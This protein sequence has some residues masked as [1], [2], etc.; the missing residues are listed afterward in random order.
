[1]YL[2]IS[3]ISQEYFLCQSIKYP[4]IW[5]QIFHYHYLPSLMRTQSKLVSNHFLVLLFLKI[6]FFKYSQ[7]HIF[8]SFK[9]LLIQKNKSTR[10]NAFLCSLLSLSIRDEEYLEQREKL[11]ADLVGLERPAHVTEVFE[12]AKA[13]ISALNQAKSRF[14]DGDDAQ[15]R[16][17]FQSLCSNPRMLDGKLLTLAQKPFTLLGERPQILITQGR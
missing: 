10:C 16:S 12:P 2:P 5:R 17:I 1:M 4:R 13:L 11:L 3:S 7:P 9:E 15:K 8:L 14:L 6:L